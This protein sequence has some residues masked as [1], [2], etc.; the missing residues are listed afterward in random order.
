MSA[1]AW[2]IK[3]TREM[4]KTVKKW[5]KNSNENLVPLRECTSFQSNPS[6]HNLSPKLFPCPT[7]EKN[8]ARKVNKRF[9]FLWKPIFSIYKR[10]PQSTQLMVNV[11]LGQLVLFWFPVTRKWLNSFERYFLAK[12]R[13]AN[14]PYQS[15]NHCDGHFK[16]LNEIYLIEKADYINMKRI[17]TETS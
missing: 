1:W 3:E 15:P 10:R 17:F 14:Q 12:S 11:Y 13:G 16:K 4:W 6:V 7:K 8:R 2:F 9:C 5:P